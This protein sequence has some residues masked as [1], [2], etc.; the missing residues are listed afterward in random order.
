MCG[1][2]TYTHFTP[3]FPPFFSRTFMVSYF[4]L[5]PSSFLAPPTMYDSLVIPYFPPSC[6]NRKKKERR[7]NYLVYQT[8]SLS[9][10][11]AFGVTFAK[12]SFFFPKLSPC[13][14]FFLT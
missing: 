4:Q 8:L 7:K 6:Q 3:S 14:S 12:A 1:E 9:P 11:L 5:S 2:I 10:F 13:F